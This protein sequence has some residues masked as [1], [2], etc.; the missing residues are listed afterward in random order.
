MYEEE[1]EL[2]YREGHERIPENW[3]RVG[4]EYGLVGL[5]VDL[6]E[7]ISKHPRLGSIGGN[8]G[9]VQTF[10][11]VDLGNVTGGAVN[12][13][14]LLEDNNLFCFAM[15]VVKTFAP[16]ALATVFKT[17]STP[18]DMLNEAIVDPL[19]DLSCPAFA[20][21]SAGGSD[22]FGRLTA[23]YPGANLTSFGGL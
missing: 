19:L 20:D 2:V 16:N 11:G 3:Y 1:G 4:E 21:L 15:E 6:V 7:W 5:N 12:G 8:M 10:A 22:L 9:E 23:T 13:V 14:S 18:L 17:L